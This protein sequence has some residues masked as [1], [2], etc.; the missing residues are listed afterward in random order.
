MRAQVGEGLL[1]RGEQ[2]YD[3]TVL[4]ECK[5][6]AEEELMAVAEVVAMLVERDSYQR[7]RLQQLLGFVHG[8]EEVSL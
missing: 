1:K 6:R 5:A 7:R 2:P 8:S 3:S 4:A